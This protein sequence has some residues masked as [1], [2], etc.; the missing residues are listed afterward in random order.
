MG[1][2]NRL[3]TANCEAVRAVAGS[4]T[5]IDLTELVAKIDAQ[6]KPGRVLAIL[7][8]SGVGKSSGVKRH[9]NRKK[10]ELNLIW[11]SAKQLAQESQTDLAQG[12]GTVIKIPQLVS[13]S[14]KPVLVVADG[15]E[16]FSRLAIKRLSEII[17]GLAAVSGLDYMVL[18]TTQPLRWS[19]VSSEVYSWNIEG[20]ETLPCSGPAFEMVAKAISG[21]SL[22]R[23]L[24]FRPELRRVV[25]N[26]AT[27]D[28]ILKVAK[29]QNLTTDRSWVGETEVIDWIWKYWLGDDGLQHQRGA[30]L[31]FLGE[32]DAKYGPVIP[33]LHVPYEATSQLGDAH[34]ASLT[35][36]DSAGVYFNHEVPS[37]WARYHVLKGEGPSRYMRI[38][39]LIRNPRWTRAIRLYSQSL[40]NRMRDCPLGRRRLARWEA[41]IVNTSLPLMFFLTVWHSLRT[42]LNFSNECGRL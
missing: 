14:A 5:K 28:Q 19:E 7:G 30:L 20:V 11:L 42:P 37:D 34:I 21:N 18:I 4:D 6:S 33:L 2:S 3:S 39:E 40:S 16:Q 35:K 15:I 24:L 29:V 38:V 13:Y 32:E 8:D 22:L 27:L 12:T 41:A 9:V 23:P 36:T 25:T 26:L 1:A 17:A 31:R 10:D